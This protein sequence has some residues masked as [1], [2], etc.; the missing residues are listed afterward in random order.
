M[1]SRASV[2]RINRRCFPADIPAPG[3]PRREPVGNKRIPKALCRT[4]TDDPFLT[5]E[6]RPGKNLSICRCFASWALGAGCRKLRCLR[7][8]VFQWCSTPTVPNLPCVLAVRVVVGARVVPAL[9]VA[10]DQMNALKGT[11]PPRGDSLGDTL[12]VCRRNA[13]VC[14]SRR[15]MSSLRHWTR[16]RGGG[17]T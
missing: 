7:G 8:G 2:H 12:A 14:S 1:L 10:S 4:R 16:R 3:W 5:M 9:S 13:T 6:A 11:D 15:P 17:P